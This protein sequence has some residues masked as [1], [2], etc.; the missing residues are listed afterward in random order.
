MPTLAWEPDPDG[1]HGNPLGSSVAASLAAEMAAARAG[2]RVIGMLMCKL[3]IKLI[4]V[5]GL[6]TASAVMATRI[7]LQLGISIPCGN[8]R[9]LGVL[10]MLVWYALYA[11]ST[12][13]LSAPVC[14]A[15]APDTRITQVPGMKVH[16]NKFFL[17]AIAP[18]TSD[19]AA[20]IRNNNPSAVYPRYSGE[21]AEV[22]VRQVPQQFRPSQ[23]WKAVVDCGGNVVR[24]A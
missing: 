15:P 3:Q 1:G 4:C 14:A 9:C 10:A 17:T 8:R 24:P 20:V 7:G 5:L 22:T 6:C 13:V 11:D 18:T 23:L 2:M 19:I 21:F 16:N 12:F